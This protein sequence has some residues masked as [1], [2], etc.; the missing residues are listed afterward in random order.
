MIEVLK[1]EIEIEGNPFYTPFEEIIIKSDE[2]NP[3]IIYIEASNQLPDSQDDVVFMKALEEERD[4]YLRKGVISWDHLHKVKGDPAFLIGEPLEVAFKDGKTF[5]KAL[6]YK[7][8]DYAQ[9]VVKLLKGKTTRLGASI[10]GF[11]KKRKL[12]NKT[13]SGITKI[14]WDEVAITYKPVNDSTLGNVSLIPIGAFAKALMAGSGVDTAQFTGGRAMIPESLQGANGNKKYGEIVSELLWR[15][16]NGDIQTEDD[17]RDFLNYQNVPF[18][19]GSLGK[20]L[21]KKFT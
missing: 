2:K 9:S 16:K 14:L 3:Y 13:L 5:V 12:L 8:V 10:G 6:L 15:M 7:T 20:L 19:Y 1:N 21:V 18:L 4:S 17:F 11:I